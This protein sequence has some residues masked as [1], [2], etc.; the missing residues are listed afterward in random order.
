MPRPGTS[1][2]I[3]PESPIS[4]TT[5]TVIARASPEAAATG[6]LISAV[7]CLAT[8]L[9]IFTWHGAATAATAHPV[10]FAVF[11]VLTAALMLLAVDIYGK[12][13]I[14]VTGVTLLATGF[15]FGVG[16]GILAGVFAAA[17]H[18]VRRRSKPHKS[19]FNAASFAIAAGAGAA[20]YHALPHAGSPLEALVPGCAGG[21]AFW[22]VNIGLLNL[23]MSVSHGIGFRQF[24]NENF[25]WLTFHYLAFGPLA[26]ACTIA[27]EKVGLIGLFAFA[28]PP[29]LLIVSVQ[30]YIEKTR[31]SVAEIERANDELR[32]SNADLTDL[33]EFAAGLA[34]QTHDSQQLAIYARKSLARLTG[35]HVDVT[36]G[37]EIRQ[38]ATPLASAGRVVGGL[39][40]QGGDAERWERLREAIEPQLATALES[41]TLAEEVRKTHLETIAALSRSMEA[42]DN[43]IGGHTERVSDIAVG[44]AKRLGFSGPDLDAIEIGALMHDIGKIGIPESILH[45]PGPLDNDE[46]I[47]M[48][49][50]PVISELILSEIELS[51]VVL[52]IARSSHERMD[53]QGYPDGLE[54]DSIPMPARIVLVADAFDALTTDRPY[55]RARRP[56]AAIDEIV[57][58]GGKQFCPLVVSALQ[59][60]Y[61]DEP[62]VLGEIGLTVIAS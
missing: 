6:F 54:G 16:A 28:L 9:I 4:S 45:K 60:L 46:W 13:S 19:V 7:A 14:S 33:F 27:Y 53:G 20:V 26:I 44:L 34:A 23:V 40:I 10:D 8:A 12:G 56:K 62:Q 41:T 31:A 43:Y 25:R 22:I 49:R 11:F 61:R 47:V 15:T 50:H 42:K 37:P 57:L 52:Q 38:G 29:A 24:W 17:V 3:D 30:Q 21:I 2:P 55:R 1:P 36:V 51:P 18:A 39:L 58:N 59:A 5:D 35:A 32:R 48:K